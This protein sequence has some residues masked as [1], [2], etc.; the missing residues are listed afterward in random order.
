MKH[1][2]NGFR[3]NFFACFLYLTSGWYHGREFEL[4][5]QSDLDLSLGSATYKLVTSGELF[6]LSEPLS[7]LVCKG[8][9]TR[10][11]LIKSKWDHICKALNIELGIVVGMKRV[12]NIITVIRHIVLEW[13]YSS[14]STCLWGT[15]QYVFSFLNH[16]VVSLCLTLCV[17]HL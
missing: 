17:S 15:P 16:S 14:Y 2:Q 8:H 9:I 5:C 1:L 12:I 6:S 10:I 11:F 13:E 7:V 3:I 4:W